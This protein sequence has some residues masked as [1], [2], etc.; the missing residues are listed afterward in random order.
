LGDLIAIS[1][2]HLLRLFE[3]Q[4][5]GRAQVLVGGQNLN[6]GILGDLIQ[7]A[8]FPL[9]GAFA[10]RRIAQ[11][12]DAPLLVQQPSHFFRRQFAA[13]MVVGC[14]VADDNRFVF[15]AAVEDD[16]RYVLVAGF[17]HRSN[18]GH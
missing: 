9:L 2:D 7:K 5:R 16:D 8:L 18:E 10:A 13:A 4:L 15:Q 3:R 11:Q 6:V 1:I 17:L 12:D 14:H